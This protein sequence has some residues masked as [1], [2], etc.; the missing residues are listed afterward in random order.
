MLQEFD[1]FTS[2]IL[3]LLAS[4]APSNV[5]SNIFSHVWPREVLL[6]MMESFSNTHMAPEGCLVELIHEHLRKVVTGRQ[7]KLVLEEKHVMFTGEAWMIGRTSL[8]L[9]KEVL[10][11]L[12]LHKRLLELV[13]DKI[14]WD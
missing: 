14:M 10:V 5:T 4:D 8:D 13:P 1:R 6:Y 3:N 11:C 7:P 9:V 12:I 2:L